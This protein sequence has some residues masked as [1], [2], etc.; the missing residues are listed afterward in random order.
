MFHLDSYNIKKDKVFYTRGGGGRDLGKFLLGMSAAGLS[1]PLPHALI[2][3]NFVTNYIDSILITFGKLCNFRDPI[4]VTFYFYE[5]THFLNCM[6]N[7]LLFTYS[8]NIL[9]VRLLTVNK[10]NCLTPKNPK[11]AT[12]L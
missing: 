7:T 8:T 2:I 3:V 6:K 5:L 4:V 1:E 12:P 11:C 9:V 10:K